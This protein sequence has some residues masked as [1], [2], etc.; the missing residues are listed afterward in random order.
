MADRL[1]LFARRGRFSPLFVVVIAAGLLGVAGLPSSGHAGAASGR[2]KEP[3]EQ[4]QKS[5]NVSSQSKKA[6]KQPTKPRYKD[7]SRPPADRDRPSEKEK[8]PRPTK[9]PP[10]DGDATN[11]PGPRPLP[12]Y[13]GPF[14]IPPPPA[15]ALVYVYDDYD[16]EPAEINGEAATMLFAATSMAFNGAYIAAGEPNTFAAVAGLLFG[17]TSFVVASRDNAQYRQLDIVLGAA[18]IALSVWNLT[19]GIQ[20]TESALYESGTLETWSAPVEA[21]PSVGYSFSF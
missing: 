8:T 5:A 16:G 12:L 9:R 19:G 18:S 13:P 14:P 10:V 4:V 21:V 2:Q 6:T 20:R 1:Q 15:P 7:R 11:R 3:G 17:A